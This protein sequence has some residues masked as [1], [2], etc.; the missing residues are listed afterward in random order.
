MCVNNYT[1][2]SEVG[3]VVVGTDMKRRRPKKIIWMNRIK[4]DVG[5]E[6]INAEMTVE[7]KGW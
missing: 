2:A 4:D 5:T 6:E 1:I 3:V 7:R